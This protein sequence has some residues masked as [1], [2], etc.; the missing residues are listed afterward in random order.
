MIKYEAKIQL[1]NGKLKGK[2]FRFSCCVDVMAENEEEAMTKIKEAYPTAEK[3][4]IVPV[5][6]N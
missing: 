4:E 5:I 2:N 3:I 6:L 1:C